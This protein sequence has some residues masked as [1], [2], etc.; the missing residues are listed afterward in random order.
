MSSQYKNDIVQSDRIIYTPSLFA[1][2]NLIHLQEIGRLKAMVPHVSKRENLPSFLFFV[3][4]EGSGFLEYENE[5]HKLEVG[6]CAFLDCRKSYAQHSSEDLW[7]LRWVH[8]YGSN[9]SGI[10]DKY[11][12]RGGKVCFHPED[13]DEYSGVLQSIYEIAG[14]NSYI[15]PIFLIR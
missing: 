1:R 14:Q 4:E 13:T 15:T 8:F 2:S 7:T 12:E 5:T 10:Y 3:V 9:M 6:D 11:M